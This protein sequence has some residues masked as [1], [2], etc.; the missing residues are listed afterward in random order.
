MIIPNDARSAV[1]VPR[2]AS[3]KSFHK[4]N[5]TQIV[6]NTSVTERDVCWDLETASPLHSLWAD[7]ILHNT[8]SGYWGGG[9][10]DGQEA[11]QMDVP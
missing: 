8:L 1:R 9:A 11:A 7:T 3:E 6:A 5:R 10:E 4:C 2:P